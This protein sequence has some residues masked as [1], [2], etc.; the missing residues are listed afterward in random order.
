MPS[1]SDLELIVSDVTTTKIN[2]SHFL[3]FQEGK[4]PQ[5]TLVKN[6]EDMN[7]FSTFC[8]SFF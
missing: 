5:A 6:N 1:R 7:N 3:F 4:F 8:V 2:C